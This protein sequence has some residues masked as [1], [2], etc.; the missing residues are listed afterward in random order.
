MAATPPDHKFVGRALTF[1][2]T[3]ADAIVE[4]IM[5]KYPYHEEPHRDAIFAISVAAFAHYCAVTAMWVYVGVITPHKA[6]I[7]KDDEKEKERREKERKK[8]EKAIKLK[9][10]REK[11]KEGQG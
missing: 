1:S 2:T 7:S 3:D 10:E 8:E 6:S 5:A 11:Q 4:H 9:E